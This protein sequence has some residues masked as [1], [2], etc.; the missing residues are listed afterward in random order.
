MT[1]KIGGVTLRYDFYPGH[2]D[3]SDGIIEKFLLQAAQTHPEDEFDQ[4]IS[5]RPEWPVFYHL[6]YLRQN[7]INWYPFEAGKTALEIG[8]DCGAITGF[9]ADACK[10]VTCVELSETRSLINAYRNSKRENVDI[11]MC[12]F[13][14]YVNHA[15]EKFDY[16]FLIGVFEYS[17]L[18][19]HA[20]QPQIEFLERIRQMLRPAGKVF[21]AIENKTGMKYWS[22]CREDHLGNYFIGIEDY[23]GV[24]TVRT[25]TKQELCELLHKTGFKKTDFYYPYPDYKFPTCV[26][27]DARLPE[28]GELT[29]NLRNFDM[30]RLLLF[31]EAKAFD[32]VIANGQFPFFSNSYLVVAE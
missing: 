10:K 5:E 28:V 31:N 19:I 17:P 15:D 18:Y 4:V 25:F 13:E 14:D 6:S 9:I 23:P 16:I 32:M 8:A 21:L 22:G 2:D 29:N 7:I 26:Y 30:D 24:E 20:P 1:K 3:Y 27:S 12:N 11:W